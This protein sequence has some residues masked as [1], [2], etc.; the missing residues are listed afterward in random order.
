MVDLAEMEA[1]DLFR[2]RGI[3]LAN[4]TEGGEGLAG[5]KHTED[6]KR[7]RAKQLTGNTYNLGR[8]H[9]EEQRQAASDRMKGNT[10]AAGKPSEK[11]GVPRTES[12]KLKISAAKRGVPSDKKGI[13]SGKKGV[14]WTAARRDACLKNRV[15]K[16]KET[17]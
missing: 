8:K 4:M 3:K 6:F 2:R 5:F 17:L 14:P 7:A 13:P 15:L 10:F 9:T 16:M 1:I 11:I 12:V